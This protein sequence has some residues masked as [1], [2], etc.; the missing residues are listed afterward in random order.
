MYAVSFIIFAGNL[1][2]EDNKLSSKEKEDGWKLL[3]DGKSLSQWKNYGSYTISSKWV[4]K[5]GM[6]GVAETSGE[7]GDIVTKEHYGNFEFKID[8]KVGEKGNSGIFLRV[9][10]TGKKAHSYALE[11]QMLDDKN[12]RTVKGDAPGPKHLSGSIYDILAAKTGAFKGYDVW[13]TTHV[14]AKDKKVTVYMNGVLVAD[15]DMSSEGYRKMFA[16]SKFAKM[17]KLA[18][19]YAKG[20]NGPLGLQ[21]HKSIVWFKNAKIRKLY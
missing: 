14:I 20:M 9:D 16:E 15:L 7:A 12:F 5:D 10:E 2:A 18:E 3:F 8:W 21:D 1:S 4:I 6:F 17:K 11:V 19:K 13:H